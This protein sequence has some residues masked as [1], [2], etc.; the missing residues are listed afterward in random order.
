MNDQQTIDTLSQQL[1]DQEAALAA[2]K[3]EAKPYLDK[4]RDLSTQKQETERQLKDA[5]LAYRRQ[6]IASLVKEAPADRAS[7]AKL[8]KSRILDPENRP[9]RDSDGTKHKQLG[10]VDFILYAI[11]RG[12]PWDSG[13]SPRTR[14]LST[15]REMENLRRDCTNRLHRMLHEHLVASHP[16]LFPK[17]KLGFPRLDLRHELSRSLRRTYCSFHDVIKHIPANGISQ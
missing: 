2:I 9:Y 17:D 3:E 8:M 12:N 6:Q 11:L 7:L 4:I 13:L 14:G 5:T 10:K 1:Q 15:R 16:D